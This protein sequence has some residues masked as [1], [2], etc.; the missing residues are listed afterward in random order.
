MP[1]S[2]TIHSRMAGQRV[3]DFWVRCQKNSITLM[4]SC[5]ARHLTARA[6]VAC[7]A[8]PWRAW[9]SSTT[10]RRRASSFL[11]A[12]LL[13]QSIETAAALPS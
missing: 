4:L 11:L 12:L 6:A 9:A 2:S 8:S 13:R 7:T 5:T 3:A 1:P 10:T